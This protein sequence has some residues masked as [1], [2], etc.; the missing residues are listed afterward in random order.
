M[1]APRSGKVLGELPT[2]RR[3]ALAERADLLRTGPL[4]C[5]KSTRGLGTVC[6]S[7]GISAALG[8]KKKLQAA[9][10]EERAAGREV[11]PPYVGRGMKG[12]LLTLLDHSR[13][14]L[15]IT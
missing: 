6:A 10:L 2:R 13:T 4:P 14:R 9:E 1:V 3:L 12:G 8:S 5:T 11:Y 7:G 15:G